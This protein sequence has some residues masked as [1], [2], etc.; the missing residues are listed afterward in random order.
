M[1]AQVREIDR[2]ATA[3]ISLG[4][5]PLTRAA[6]FLDL[7]GTLAEFAP[8]PDAVVA[9]ARRTALLREL[10]AAL[11][12][13]LAVVSGRT[14]ADIDRIV[15]HVAVCAAGV[16]GLERRTAEG[17]LVR[18]QA[19]PELAAAEQELRAFAES[20][21]GVLVET[22][23][24]SVAVHF[25]LARDQA[26][27]ARAL[28]ARIAERTGL[29]LQAGDMVAELRTPGADKGSAVEAFM[30]EAP[31]AGATPIFAGDDVTDEDAFAIVEALGGTGVLVGPFRDSAASARLP[32]VSEVF[33]WLERSLRSGAFEFQS[34]SVA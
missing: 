34:R 23:Q 28:A 19:H 21:P 15:E 3:P 13:R 2:Q 5:V 25:R 27:A 6:L 29:R 31:F 9:D 33:S 16:H 12:G 20:R 32:G 26:D 22:K 8:T 4:P 10:S 11:D 17:D 18:A 1:T 7:D 14:L 24:L 30:A